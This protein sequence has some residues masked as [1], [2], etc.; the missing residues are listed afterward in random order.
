MLAEAKTTDYT[1]LLSTEA[2]SRA[3]T[4]WFLQWDALTQFSLA[5][6]MDDAKP[7]RRGRRLGTY[8]DEDDGD[9]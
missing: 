8:V 6:T 9:R 3:V 4:K 7:R 2:G 1:K 5:K